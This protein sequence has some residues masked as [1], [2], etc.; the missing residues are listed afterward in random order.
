MLDIGGNIVYMSE[1]LANDVGLSY[2]KEKSFGKGVNARIL[3]IDGV[4]R[5][6][7]I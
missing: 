6:A 2:T 3:P 1:E 5:G 4:I 7:H